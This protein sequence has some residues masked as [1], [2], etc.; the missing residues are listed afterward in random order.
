MTTMTIPKRYRWI[1]GGLLAVAAALAVVLPSDPVPVEL[2]PVTRGPLRVT[3][4]EEGEAR[5]RERYLASAPIPGRLVPL[6][7]EAGDPVAAGDV[8]ARVYPLP[9]D[10]RARTEAARRL[11]A[12]EAAAEAAGAAVREAEAA[13]LQAARNRERAEALAARDV[14]APQTLED[15]R[16]AES[17]AA[18]ALEEARGAAHAAGHEVDA[19]R[20]VLLDADGG[21]GTGARAVR[22][23]AAGR[24]LRVYEERERVVAAGAPIIEIGDP[25]DL[26]VVVDVLT[27]DA[28][29]LREGA[30]ALVTPGTAADTLAG[31]VRRIEPSA[32][33]KV[34]PLGVEEQ[35]VNVIV[36]L[37][38]TAAGLGDRFRVDVALVAWSADDVLRVPVGALFRSGGAWAVFVMADG[39]ARL[40]TIGIGQRGR[41]A[42]EVLHG[43]A[44]GEEVVLYPGADVRDGARVQARPSVE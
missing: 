13:R 17:M 31:R 18:A 32:F 21:G 5:V 8:L 30:R 15:A 20:A 1:G 6:D 14:I 43:L 11:E 26:E 4:D 27:E 28:A 9:L 29:R 16:T 3:V 36:A 12:A 24:V 19:A 44:E 40:R 37:D 34:S 33:T 23:P 10:E 2:E 41:R 38:G 39:R 42:A 25:A 35:R 22:A 7:R